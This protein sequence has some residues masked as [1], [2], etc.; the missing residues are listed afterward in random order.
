MILNFSPI[1]S[2]ILSLL[3]INGIYNF[4][5]KTSFYTCKLIGKEIL[6]SSIL[7]F[8]LIINLISFLT[9]TYTLYFKINEDLIKFIAIII[10]LF[11]VYKPFYLKFIKF[12]FLKKSFKLNLIFIILFLYFLLSLSPVTDP[13]S[14]DY[15]ITVPLYQLNFFDHPFAKY[16]LTSQLSGSGESFLLYG[17]SLGALNLSQ[18]LQFFSLFLIIIYILNFKYKNKKIYE[19]RKLYLCLSILVIPTLIF[20]VSTSKPQL[21]PILT[22]FICLKIALIDL[23]KMERKKSSISCLLI[24]LLLFFSIQIKFSFL[25]SS[26]LI[27]LLVIFE[28]YKK[29]LL[30]K[31]FIS[32][33]LLFGLIMLPREL[34]EFNNL[35]SNFVFNFLNPVTDTL[36]SINFNTSLKHGAGNSPFIPIWLFFPYP[37]ISQITHTLG[38]TVLYFLFYF[39]IK[40][41]TAKKIF[42]ISLLFIIIALIF[43]Q[44]TGRFFLEPFI[45]LLFFSIICKKNFNSKLQYLFEKITIIYSIFFII[46]LGYYTLNLFKGNLGKENFE[47]VLKKNAD[48]YLLY[49]WANEVIPDDSIIMTTHRSMAF[50]K[51]KAITYEFRLFPTS[52]D[53]KIFENY[54]HHIIEENP[55]YILYTS[56]ELDDKKDILKNCRGKLFRYKKNVGNTTGRNPLSKKINYDGYIFHL[57]L[58]KLKDC[59]L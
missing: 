56:T 8:C 24:F 59:K 5:H 23:P 13:D 31:S 2:I 28:M 3:I 43:A 10:I 11:G 20:L 18:F 54:M 57:N 21:F 7:N 49:E 51:H 29:K 37:N 25:L 41:I 32:S 4:A 35:N 40:D 38:F 44:P 55:S 52:F 9:F 1:F 27:S 50:Y 53:Q 42:L 30:I 45:W 15:H 26:F 39:Q 46:I 22:N 58:K 16:W 14:L 6:F 19:E 36:S 47:D 34:Y 33:I 48:G 17:L 12:I